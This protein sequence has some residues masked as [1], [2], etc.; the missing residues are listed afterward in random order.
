MESAVGA[1]G[2]LINAIVR[3]V[4]DLQ[5][6]LPDMYVRWVDSLPYEEPDKKA[7]LQAEI[8]NRNAVYKELRFRYEKIDAKA[9]LK[10]F[11][12]H[13]LD[14]N[15]L[16]GELSVTCYKLVN[17]LQTQIMNAEWEKESHKA[18]IDYDDWHVINVVKLAI[19]KQVGER[20][21]FPQP[22]IPPA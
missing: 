1:V 2:L 14:H 4:Y 21:S 6:Q 17:L 5:D 22:P 15:F 12:N 16:L 8:G 18:R 11:L 7:L 19:S 9:K 10:D 3:N 20:L 13:L